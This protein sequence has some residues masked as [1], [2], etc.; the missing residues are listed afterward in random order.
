M[1]LFAYP[2]GRPKKD[3]AKA[4]V[5]L[6]REL[7]F[8]GAVSTSL[9]AAHI[10][11]DPFPGITFRDSRPGACVHSDLSRR[12]PR[13]SCACAAQLRDACLD[14]DNCAVVPDRTP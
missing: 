2:N 5:A 9:G 14:P 12:W 11:S 8:D 3:Y 4:S 13:I 6:V 10:S 7:G 1:R